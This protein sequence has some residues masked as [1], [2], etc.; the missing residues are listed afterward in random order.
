[1]IADKDIELAAT[2]TANESPPDMNGEQ[3]GRQVGAG[4]RDSPI[5]GMVGGGG[6]VPGWGNCP[7]PTIRTYRRMLNNP[8]VAIGRMAV[9]APVRASDWSVQAADDA[10]AGARELVEDVM[11]DHR[12]MLVNQALQML[13]FGHK[14]FEIIWD[15]VN[16]SIVPRKFK[17]LLPEK[18]IILADKGT[19]AYR[20][21]KQ[22]RGPNNEPVELMPAETLL[23]V[24]DPK[25]SDDYLGRSLLENI[26]CSAW[27]PWEQSLHREGQQTTKISGSQIVVR[28]P[29]GQSKD[30]NGGDRD[31]FELAQQIISHLAAGKGIAAPMVFQK[32][33]EGAIARGV[34]PSKL[35]AWTIDFLEP[36]TGYVPELLDGMRHKEA[37]ILRG[38]MVPER[39]V[40]EGKFGTKAES[41]SQ[42]EFVFVYAQG[43]LDE[44]VQC[45]NW[46]VVDRILAFNYGTEA[47]GKVWIGAEPIIDA[48]VGLIRDIVKTVLTNPANADL[49]QAL[50]DF[51]AQLDMVGVPKNEDPQADS[52]RDAVERLRDQATGTGGQ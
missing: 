40:S 50:T 38:I 29:P 11:I 34:D 13:D 27:W 28:Y 48:K 41:E 52:M 4:D 46:Y 14:P 36:G 35:L 47:R 1:M 18:T 31:N 44:I 23:F 51:D 26:R 45:V 33:A 7:G 9:N 39:S 17:S 37:M 5:M 22:D 19:G 43:V 24:N 42:A 20:G 8:I 3:T 16:G 32:W 6:V 15:Q 21:L 10:P 2:D 25:A 30:A 49:L 12:P